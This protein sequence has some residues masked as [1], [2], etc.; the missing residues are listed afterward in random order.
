MEQE[1]LLKEQ[2]EKLAARKKKAAGSSGNK[3]AGKRYKT[4]ADLFDTDADLDEI[5][6]E[7][8]SR[9]SGEGRGG[10]KLSVGS[11]KSRSKSGLFDS[12]S[13]DQEVVDEQEE[14]D[15]MIE[16]KEE[17]QKMADRFGKDVLE[18]LMKGLSAQMS[19]WAKEKESPLRNAWERAIKKTQRTVAKLAEMKEDGEKKLRPDETSKLEDPREDIEKK[20]ENMVSSKRSSLQEKLHTKDRDSNL[21]QEAKYQGQEQKSS[22][23]DDAAVDR[24]INLP[25]REQLNQESLKKGLQAERELG[26]ENLYVEKEDEE[27]EEEE[28]EIMKD[29]VKLRDEVQQL[30]ELSRKALN[31]RLEVDKEMDTDDLN[32][33]EQEEVTEGEEGEGEEEVDELELDEESLEQLGEDITEEIQ[34]Q[35]DGIGLGTNGNKTS[36]CVCVPMN[37][38]ASP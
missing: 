5:T 4:I 35:L 24:N 18:E 33:E 9:K 16:D 34:K 28:E 12:G 10:V 32:T 26:R 23:T 1:Q 29:K 6:E 8:V 2:R 20:K 7:I 17:L 25:S 37:C 27:E 14:E 3:P 19:N 38:C 13:E 22:R 36:L 11:S 31:E 21:N 30:M 15:E